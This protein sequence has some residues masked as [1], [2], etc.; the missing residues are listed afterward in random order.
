MLAIFDCIF[1]IEFSSDEIKLTHMFLMTS[2]KIDRAHYDIWR[3]LPFEP[4][5][6]KA[7]LFYPEFEFN[8]SS[9]NFLLGTHSSVN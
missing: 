7:H 5:I 9:N 8:I 2:I 3:F 1:V 4:N 6:L